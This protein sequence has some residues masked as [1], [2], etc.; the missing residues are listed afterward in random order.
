MN[1]NPNPNPF[2]A[3]LYSRKFWVAVVGCAQTILFQFVPNFPPA[4]W[5]SIDALCS[6]VIITIAAEDVA[7]KVGANANNH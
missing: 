7:A 1:N 4:V 2:R 5:Q 3:L 6:V